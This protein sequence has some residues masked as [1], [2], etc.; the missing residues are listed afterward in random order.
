MRKTRK[1]A[2]H[3]LVYKAACGLVLVCFTT[4]VCGQAYH[5][6]SA[7]T[8]LWKSIGLLL[9]IGLSM[10]VVVKLWSSWEDIQDGEKKSSKTK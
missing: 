2:K 10:H 3:E 7:S 8:I 6:V 9:A 5:G 4:F 1:R